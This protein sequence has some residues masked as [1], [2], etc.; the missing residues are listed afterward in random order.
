MGAAA[1]NINGNAIHSDLHIPC[2]GQLLPLSD[3]NKA[4]IQNK[5]AE[6]ELVV[7]DEISMVSSKL[8]NQV[9]KRLNEIFT[10]GKDSPF[11]GKSVLVCGYL[12]QLP[13]V[14][15]KPVYTFNDSETKEGFISMDLWWK[16]KLAEL[17]QL[18]K[19]DD[20]CFVNLLSKI[21]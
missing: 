2:R 1:I 10:L 8:F 15:A 6:V 11:S 9:H 13:P 12:S 4:E 18:M 14:R 20:K 5:Y 21:R 19:Q 17:D 7:I 3:T 16:F